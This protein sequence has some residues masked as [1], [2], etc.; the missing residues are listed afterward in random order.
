MGYGTVKFVCRGILV[1]PDDSW[2]SMQACNN[3][4]SIR[5]GFKIGVIPV[6]CRPVDD[7]VYL[8]KV[9]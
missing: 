1:P 7:A 4:A 8:E 6:Q 9:Q 2:T 5:K 3:T